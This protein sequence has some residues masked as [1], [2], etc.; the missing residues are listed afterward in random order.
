MIPVSLAEPGHGTVCLVGLGLGLGLG[1]VESLG[2]GL[3]GLV[4]V[5]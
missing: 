2:L 4:G 3:L 1:Q 5:S